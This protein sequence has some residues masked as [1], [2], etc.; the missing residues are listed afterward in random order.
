M[1]HQW[2]IAVISNVWFQ[3]VCQVIDSGLSIPMCFSQTNK[4]KGKIKVW[5]YYF[6]LI[7]LFLSGGRKGRRGSLLLR[8]RFGPWSGGGYV[9]Q[10]AGDQFFHPC[11]TELCMYVRV[12]VPLIHI[13][14]Y[15]T[16]GDTFTGYFKLLIST[17]LYFTAQ[18]FDFIWQLC[19]LYK[20]I[21]IKTVW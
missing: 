3:G 1:T 7:Y 17:S 8:P 19:S 2:S 5:F 10:P 16:F 20:L 11:K 6:F 18:H 4:A 21:Y 15:C 14:S 13:L 9:F 12:C